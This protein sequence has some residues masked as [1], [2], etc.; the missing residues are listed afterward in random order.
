MVA[1]QGPRLARPGV[2][3]HQVALGGAFDQV[4]E[5]VHQRRD[6]AEERLGRGAR[7]HRMGARQRGHQAG[8]GL[9]LPPMVV[10]RPPGVLFQPV[11]GA[12]VEL[13]A[14]QEQVAQRT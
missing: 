14:G 8:A 12:A 9:G 4:A 10:D 13:L 5:V 11:L 2:E 7:L 1:E 6:H 3:D